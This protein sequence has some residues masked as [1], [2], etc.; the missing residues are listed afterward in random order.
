MNLTKKDV[1]QRPFEYACHEGNYGMVGI[2][3]AGRA[4]DKAVE[5]A[6]KKGVPYTPRPDG[7]G[8]ER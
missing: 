2:L 5:E 1:S 3:L 7:T 6:A 4:E 8:E